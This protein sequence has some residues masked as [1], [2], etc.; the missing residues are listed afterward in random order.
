MILSLTKNG[1][2]VVR[3]W[4]AAFAAGRISGYNRVGAGGGVLQNMNTDSKVCVFDKF[5][6]NLPTLPPAQV[7]QDFGNISFRC[8]ELIGRRPKGKGKILRVFGPLESAKFNLDQP[9]ARAVVRPIWHGDRKWTKIIFAETFWHCARC[10]CYCLS[11]GRRDP[12]RI[13]TNKTGCVSA[14]LYALFYFSK[15]EL[16]RARVVSFCSLCNGS[17]QKKIGLE[18]WHT[19]PLI[20]LERLTTFRTKIGQILEWTRIARYA[21]SL[22]FYKIDNREVTMIKCCTIAVVI[23]LVYSDLLRTSNF[24]S[25][26]AARQFVVIHDL[27]DQKLPSK[28]GSGTSESWTGPCLF[29]S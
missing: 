3:R 25:C 6:G 20:Y 19:I 10:L 21:R 12:S 17:C 26:P 23:C 7:R 15:I 24:R 13:E 16:L 11:E 18:W 14:K 28:S 5:G 2:H 1:G 9:A 22:V 8:S 29:S 4:L 27:H